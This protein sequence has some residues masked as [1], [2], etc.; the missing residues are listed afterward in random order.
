[1]FAAVLD[2]VPLQGGGIDLDG[3]LDQ[4]GDIDDL[5]HAGD[6]GIALLHGDD[7]VDMLDVLAQVAEFEQKEALL[8]LEFVV[9]GGQVLGDM[10]AARVGG[11]ELLQPPACFAP[12]AGDARQVVE[13]Q[14]FDGVNDQATRHVDA[15]QGVAHVVQHVAGDLRHAGQPGSLDKALVRIFQLPLRNLEGGNVFRDAERADDVS[16]AVAPRHLAGQRPGDLATGMSFLLHLADE[17]LASA[18]DCVLV[19][20][21]HPGVLFGEQVGIR[22][23]DDLVGRNVMEGHERLAEV[24]ETRLAVLEV[25]SVREY[26]PAASATVRV[27]WQACLPPA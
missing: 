13:V 19:L 20:Q 24:D 21:R 4:L 3:I 11:E 15:V 17:R 22:L 10:L 26:C 6:L 25:D 16:L 14:P 27:R 8:L 18:E 7:L 2:G 23:A 9:D 12:G 1:M 5:L